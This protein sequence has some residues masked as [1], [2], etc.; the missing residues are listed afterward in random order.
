[1][2]QSTEFATNS[3]PNDDY[4]PSNL[5]LPTYIPLHYSLG[6]NFNKILQSGSRGNDLTPQ[7]LKQHINLVNQYID[8][9]ISNDSLDFN[10]NILNNYLKTYKNLIISKIKLSQIEKL[11]NETI[12]KQYISPNLNLNLTNLDEYH[13]SVNPSVEEFISSKENELISSNYQINQFIKSDKLYQLL[14][15]LTFIMKN[16]EDP[17]PDE[18]NDDDDAIGI[19]GGKVSLKDP[20]TLNQFVEPVITSCNH[21]F[22]KSSIQQQMLTHR[23]GPFECPISGCDS[24]L[25]SNSFKID[26]LMKARVKAFNKMEKNKDDDL[27]LV[28]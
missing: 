21:T 15:S 10:E 20:I 3:N 19:S 24:V 2:S 7:A 17:V 27:D 11:S 5:S 28:N 22:E 12:L 26:K 1:M 4:L 14:R 25:N 8:H 13:Q 9:I 6:S 18:D 16:P 23:Y